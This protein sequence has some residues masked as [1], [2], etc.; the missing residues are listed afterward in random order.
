MRAGVER[1]PGSEMRIVLVHAGAGSRGGVS[2]DVGALAHGARAAGDDVRVVGSVGTA[3]RAIAAGPDVVHAFGCLPSVVTF[4]SMG[5]ARLRGIPVVWTPVFHPS[6]VRSWRGYGWIRAMAVF[7]RVAPGWA[8]WT[9]AIL[10]STDEEAGLFRDRGAPRVDLIPPAVAFPVAESSREDV[11]AF[12]ERFEIPDGP[13]LLVVGRRD[14]RKALPF[15]AA[16]IA[17]VRALAPD[18]VMALA[19]SEGVEGPGLVSLGWLSPSELA[20][21]YAAADLVFVSSLYESFSRVVIEA[22]AHARAVVVTDRVG[23]AP[24]VAACGGEVVAYGDA[25][26]AAAAIVSLLDDPARRERVATAGRAI[27]ADRYDLRTA[28]G[29]TLDLYR[30]LAAGRHEREVSWMSR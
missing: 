8:R 14:S 23:L 7:D 29:S 15:A 6:R 27:A 17:R 2:V 20:C 13:L 24:V 19:G 25:P 3:A 18:A 21:A 1:T 12:R 16:V 30:E 22:W 11:R 28:V 10:A 9:D 4:A 5:S 26:A